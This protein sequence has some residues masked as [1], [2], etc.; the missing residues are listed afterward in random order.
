MVFQR[1]RTPHVLEKRKAYIL[2]LHPQEHKI[3]LVSEY[4]FK[5]QPSVIELHK[6]LD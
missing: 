2:K 5:T 4:K 6:H 3:A 1:S